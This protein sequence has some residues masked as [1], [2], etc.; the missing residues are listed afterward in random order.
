MLI[1][2]YIVELLIK[3]DIDIFFAFTGGAIAPL[4]D[5]VSK[6]SAKIVFFQHEQ[7]AAMACEGV[8]RETGKIACVLVTSGPGIQNTL[9][10]IC[11]CWYDSIPALFISGQV[12][13]SES[14]DVIN[15]KP[16]QRGFQEMPV[17][18]SFCHFTKFSKKVTS[19]TIHH[20]TD[21]F[22]SAIKSIKTGRYGPALIDLPVNVQMSTFHNIAE[23]V[24]TISEAKKPLIIYGLG[25]RH[26]KS[27]NL[28]KNLKVPFVTSWAAKDLFPDDYEFNNGSIGIY[29]SRAA[30]FAI[31][32]SDC[33]IIL[34]SRL[35]TRQSGGRF[36][37]FSKKSKKIM[38][39]IDENEINKLT[40]AGITIDLSVVCD[41]NVFLS[42]PL[43]ITWMNTE[44]M[45][46]LSNW[47]TKYIHP[48][49][50]VYTFLDS[51]HFPD[52]TT[53]IPDCG[54]NLIWAMQT[55]KIKNNQRCQNMF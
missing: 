3:N 17:V 16:R 34:G 14:L 5:A 36:E 30:N 53:V 43:N 6:T 26:S 23:I 24:K 20:I 28:V 1:S 15:A 18:D 22:T 8:F 49:G 47:K 13:M 31:Q 33:L 32:N 39:D 27:E 4:I 21:V 44:W 2:D 19:S 38:V 46:T 11:G 42:L 7:A 51:I 48:K 45:D 40:E 37:K 35:D 12:N 9:N 25:I 29:G 52:N 54:G 50:G 55:V 41:L 10:G